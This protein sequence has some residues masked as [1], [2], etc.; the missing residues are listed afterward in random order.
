MSEN[1][2]PPEFDRLNDFEAMTR[3]ET[4]DALAEGKPVIIPTGSIEQHGH[5]LPVGTDTYAVRSVAKRVAARLDG[6]LVPFSPIGVTP[7][8]MKMGGAISLRPE[9]YMDYFDDVIESLIKH[10][11]EQVVIVNWHEVNASSIETV[12]T[13][14]QDRH[15]DVTF[16]IAEAHFT[17]RDLYADYHDLT[18][19][20]PL[21]VLPVMGDHPE[22]VHLDRATDAGEEGHAS[23]MDDLRRS[24]NAYPIIPD[25]RIMYPSGWYGDL[26]EV[27]DYDGEEFLERVAEACAD[28]VA[29][30]LE[31]MGSVDVDDV[32]DVDE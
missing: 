18:H 25:V 8:H 24:D 14:V 2:S 7:L 19:G 3:Y 5:H 20:G 23:M 17:A 29:N 6:L 4:E 26:S 11:A 16:V 15:Q 27:E 22:L 10:G 21:E 28:D 30:A 13:R 32:D 12:A 9:T 31:V 1:E